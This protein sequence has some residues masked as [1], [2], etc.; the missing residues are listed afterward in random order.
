[1]RHRVD[2][3]NDLLAFDGEAVANGSSNIAEGR[4]SLISSGWHASAD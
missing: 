2:P 4:G 1:M 3:K